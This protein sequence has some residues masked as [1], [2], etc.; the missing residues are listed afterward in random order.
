M[1]DNTVFYHG[2]KLLGDAWWMVGF[3][4]NAQ[5]FI[6]WFPVWPVLF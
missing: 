1:D 2:G 4:V 5:G 3:D 6:I